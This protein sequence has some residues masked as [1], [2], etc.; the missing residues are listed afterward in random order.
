MRVDV[1]L[2]QYEAVA[3]LDQALPAFVYAVHAL[4]ALL[5]LLAIV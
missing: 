3:Y 4:L 2:A 5:A 1:L